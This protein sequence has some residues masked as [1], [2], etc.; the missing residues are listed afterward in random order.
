MEGDFQKIRKAVRNPKRDT[1]GEKSQHHSHTLAGHGQAVLGKGNHIISLL[2]TLC[3]KGQLFWSDIKRDGEA[4]GDDKT[5]NKKSR[6]KDSEEAEVM[7]QRM[8]AVAP[9]PEGSEPAVGPSSC[10]RWKPLGR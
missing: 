10:A 5:V 3:Q 9:A 7:E 1:A 4:S 6:S 8:T 2:L